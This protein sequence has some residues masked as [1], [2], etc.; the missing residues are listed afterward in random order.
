MKKVTA[1]TDG[2]GVYADDSITHYIGATPPGV[3]LEKLEEQSSTDEL[4]ALKKGGFTAG[5][6]IELKQAKL[7]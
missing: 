1:F 4:I 3:V 5:E 6:I 7:L 2:V